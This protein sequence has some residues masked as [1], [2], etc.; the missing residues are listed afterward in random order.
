MAY[1]QYKFAAMKTIEKGLRLRL[2]VPRRWRH[3]GH[4]YAGERVTG[5]A[6][7]EITFVGTL[8]S[9]SHMTYVMNPKVV[10]HQLASFAP[11]HI[12]I[13]EDPHSMIGLEVVAAAQLVCPKAAI[14]FFIWD[15][16]D[17]RHRGLRGLLKTAFTSWSF[18]RTA[19]VICGNRRAQA[20]LAAKDFMGRS[21]VLP[22]LAVEPSLYSMT[23]SHS[24]NP[25][26]I[27]FV[28]RLVPEK[29]LFVLFDALSRILD[30]PW[31]LTL[32]G[33][34]PSR[35]LLEERAKC[36]DGRVRFLGAV[37]QDAVPSLFG[38][39][40]VFVLPSI[41]TRAWEE[42]FG[43]AMAQAMMSSCG[44]IATRS[45][46]IPEVLGDAGMLI[47]ENDVAAL[48]MA[49]RELVTNGTLRHT[50]GRLARRRAIERFN[51]TVV[52]AG[53]LDALGGA[54]W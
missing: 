19:L 15:N 34:G 24:R 46:A 44:I 52:A 37:S 2:L 4:T 36:L 38:D 5:I 35:A 6:A 26:T 18:A 47:P 29:G 49:L 41:A 39:F 27:A 45:G 3:L 50:L 11:T 12:L 9:A 7:D 25:P 23:A 14:G 22:Q 53:Y 10:L 51:P 33:D 21:C 20:L 32:V 16:I 31:N 30:V 54:G 48:E 1:A 28:G 17:R 43:Y 40:D 13:E 42:Q 8:F